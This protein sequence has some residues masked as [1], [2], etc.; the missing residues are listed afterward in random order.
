MARLLIV[1]VAGL[2][3][4]V[5]AGAWAHRSP[6]PAER[7][8]ITAAAHRVVGTK[9]KV[10]LIRVS[11]VAAGHWAISRVT[12]FFNGQPDNAS[13]IY[14]R[15]AGRWTVTKHSPGTAGYQCG[16]AMPR[17]AQRDLGLAACR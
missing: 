14:H 17:S 6:T 10:S 7:H 4:L 2:T 15:V 11:T 1:V 9:A 5:P 13:V 3:L 12:L 8:A 16:I